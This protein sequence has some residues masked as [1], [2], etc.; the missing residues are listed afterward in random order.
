MNDLNRMFKI[1]FLK[2]IVGTHIF[3]SKMSTIVENSWSKYFYPSLNHSKQAYC[4]TH[5]PHTAKLV[6]KRSS[7]FRRTYVY[8]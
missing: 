4:Q 8:D 5:M 2:Y 6:E 3:L 1:D 7:L